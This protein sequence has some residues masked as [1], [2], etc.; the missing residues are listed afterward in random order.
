M[1]DNT[2][3]STSASIDWLTLTDTRKREVP[4]LWNLGEQLLRKSQDEGNVRREW[5][6]KSYDGYHAG[7]VTIGRR[8]DSDI[9]Q[10]SGAMADEWFDDAWRVADHCTRIDLAVTQWGV[11][12]GGEYLE[13][14][15]RE[16]EAW[17]EA[18]GRTIG[19]KLIYDNFRPST[20]YLGSRESDLYARI[21]DKGLE[22]GDPAY[23]GA[24]R[25]E[26]E[27]KGQPAQRTATA[28]HSAGARADR[29]RSAVYNH[30]T[31]R[32]CPVPFKCDGPDLS[33]RT[34]RAPSD[35]ST[36]LAWLYRV[37]RPSVQRL[38]LS[39]RSEAVFEALGV[40]KSV[41]EAFR[42]ANLL[43]QDAHRNELQEEAGG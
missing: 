20:L 24:W 2:V 35:D 40:P 8:E 37:A 7:W 28:L 34:V 36:R 4:A 3:S 31:R 29:I 19:T 25:W 14:A 6:W 5:R 13:R 23:E 42:L 9:L 18:Q 15:T 33:I 30:F 21:Y 1:T 11:E 12:N 41:A 16:V 43:E 26:L 38:L 39:G 27:I 17:K 10:L 32:G 22:S